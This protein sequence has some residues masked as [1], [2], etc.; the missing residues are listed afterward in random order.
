MPIRGLEDARKG[1]VAAHRWGYPQGTGHPRSPRPWRREISAPRAA[2]AR[3]WRAAREG[4]RRRGPAAAPPDMA[5]WRP[6]SVQA[7]PPGA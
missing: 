3:T 7:G 6:M 4:R 2:G 1:G 5:R